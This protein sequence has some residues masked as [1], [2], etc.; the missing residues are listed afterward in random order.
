M[1]RSELEESWRKTTEYLLDARSHLSEAAEGICTD[2]IAEFHE[3]LDHNE[4]ERALDALDM[5]VA[6]TGFET[7]RVFELMAA[8]AREMGLDV[9]AAKYGSALPWWS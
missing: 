8:A 5:A 2:E 9:R 3:F 1:D 6:K 4:L 7:Q